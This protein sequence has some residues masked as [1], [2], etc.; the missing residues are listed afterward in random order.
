F[1]LRRQ[2]N[3]IVKILAERELP[4]QISEL[5]QRSGYTGSEAEKKFKNLAEQPAKLAAFFRERLDFYLREARGFAYDVVNAVLVADSNDVAD[6]VK[7]AA[8]VTEVRGSADFAAIATS[9]KRIKNILRQ[10]EQAKRTWPEKF[11]AEA[12]TELGE[13]A[14]VEAVEEF[15]PRVE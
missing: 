12:L 13:K 6:A 10:A 14:L 8:A 1:A 5:M 11:E 3:G 9:F 2:A 4:I 15:G 7:R